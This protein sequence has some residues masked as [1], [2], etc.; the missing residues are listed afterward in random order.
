MM[1]TYSPS[2]LWFCFAL[3]CRELAKEYED[4]DDDDE[5]EK[6][7][8]GDGKT[9]KGLWVD[10]YAPRHYTDLLSDDVSN[11]I[12]FFSFRVFVADM[13]STSHTFFM[14]IT[15]RGSF[16]TDLCAGMTVS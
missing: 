3:L 13:G 4:D 12:I 1:K 6:T 10:R 16:G 5:V 11:D 9:R 15:L 8:D 2:S 7:E 14:K